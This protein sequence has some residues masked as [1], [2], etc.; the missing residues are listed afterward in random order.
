MN[1]EE[2]ENLTHSMAC[3][4]KILPQLD[5][6]PILMMLAETVKNNHNQVFERFLILRIV[7]KFL[8]RYKVFTRKISYSFK[9]TR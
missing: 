1:P 8:C 6:G 5:F 2:Q 4:R 9:E 3:L 7:F